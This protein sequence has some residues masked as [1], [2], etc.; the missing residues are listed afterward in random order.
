MSGP[1]IPYIVEKALLLFPRLKATTMENTV[2]FYDDL[3]ST[4][5]NY[6]LALMLFDAIYIPFGFEGLCPP[7]LG[8]GHYAEISSA[9]MKLLPRLLLVGSIPRVLA[10]VD[11]VS[12]ESK[13]GHDLL[14]RIMALSVPGF[15]P[16]LP[17]L[18]PLW[19]SSTNLF[20]FCRSHHFYSRIQG[21]KG[22]FYDNHM[23]SGIFLCAIWSSEYADVVTT[24]QSHIDLFPW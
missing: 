16:T 20:K 5:L 23:K 11:A 17:L 21:E 6:L 3:Q 7:G 14:F 18:V 12:M 15:D 10:I 4:G 9:F 24:L 8:T 13:N 2:K 1:S 19:T 22:I